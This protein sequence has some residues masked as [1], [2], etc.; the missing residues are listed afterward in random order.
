MISK[1]SVKHFKSIFDQRLDLAP[2][3][4]FCGV[5]SSGKSS[6]L[7]SVGILAQSAQEKTEKIA[8]DGKLFNLGTYDDIFCKKAKKLG[9]QEIEI[10]FSILNTENKHIN[11]ELGLKRGLAIDEYK[12]TLSIAQFNMNSN[13]TFIKW[14]WNLDY[15]DGPRLD[16][17]SLHVI[18]NQAVYNDF[19]SEFEKLDKPDISFRAFLP[20]E[21]YY[22]SYDDDE[23][24]DE[25]L[26]ESVKYRE[27]LAQLP[28]N[29][30][31]LEEAKKY[32][33]DCTQ[34]VDLGGLE[35]FLRFIINPDISNFDDDDDINGN[36][37]KP[38][39][40]PIPDFDNLFKKYRK[41]DRENKNIFEFGL[42]EWYYILSKLNKE[43][44]E[45]VINELIRQD[46]QDPFLLQLDCYLWD[47]YQKNHRDNLGTDEYELIGSFE[48]PWQL[49]NMKN[50]LSDYFTLK[51]KFFGPH[52]DVKGKNYE[53]DIKKI[54]PVKRYYSPS[55]LMNNEKVDINFTLALMEWLQYI[56]LADNFEYQEDLL[57]RFGDEYFSISQLGTG[58]NQVVSILVTCLSAEPGTTIILQEPESH[59]HPKMQSR[60]ADF[61]IAMAFSGRQCLIE[62]HSEYMIDQLRYRIADMPDSKKL[63]EKTKLYFVSKHS[64]ISYYDDIKINEYADLSKW[65]EDFFDMSHLKKL[66]IM[67]AVIKKEDKAQYNE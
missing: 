36:S 20:E 62:T 19:T 63:L 58:V 55:S 56:V 43:D 60:L 13:N 65:P 14:R 1:W 22:Y 18:K 41:K 39:D 57:L 42:A 53:T 45:K 10:C 31:T 27:L 52:L 21:L 2:L 28:P 23:S 5:N 8:L 29:E 46:N 50:E 24:I 59:L 48:L 9:L 30:L 49:E 33:V 40:F 15:Y 37:Q 44:K 32:V 6:F 35:R 61:F 11:V 12:K 66:E 25:K 51:I 64:G 17:D 67:D 54:G 16:I 7:Q 34:K 26:K 4:L 3:T 38:P 47:Y